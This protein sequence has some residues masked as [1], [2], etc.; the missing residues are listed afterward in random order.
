MLGL[1]CYYMPNCQKDLV[2]NINSAM[3]WCCIVITAFSLWWTYLISPSFN[4]NLQNVLILLKGLDVLCRCGKKPFRDDMCEL[5]IWAQNELDV[6]HFRF[7]VAG[8]SKN[9][10]H[11]LPCSWKDLF[12]FL[13]LKIVTISNSAYSTVILIVPVGTYNLTA[14]NYFYLFVVARW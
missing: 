2:D 7:T 12:F 5:Y 6:I 14:V 8:Y 9:V 10:T 13:K 1:I 11:W 3:Q 4:L